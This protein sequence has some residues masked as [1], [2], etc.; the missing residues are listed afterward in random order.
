[1]IVGPVLVFGGL[2]ALFVVLGAPMPDLKTTG[3]IVVILVICL[4]VMRASLA[5]GPMKLCWRCKGKG[6]IGGLL[7]GRAEC[8]WCD[9]KGIRPRA[10]S[11][12]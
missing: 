7:G 8:N 1:M 6:H 5:L 12:K 11:G 3:W 9:G 10:G 4:L 2:I